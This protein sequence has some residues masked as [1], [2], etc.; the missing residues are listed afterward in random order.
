M[1]V[2]RG[3]RW[4]LN[5]PTVYHFVHAMLPFVSDETGKLTEFSEHV[6]V[7]QALCAFQLHLCSRV[8]PQDSCWC[9]SYYIIYHASSSL[10]A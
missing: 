8:C 4:N 6:A 9:S 2:R 10:L 7:A 3:L 1:C 5:P